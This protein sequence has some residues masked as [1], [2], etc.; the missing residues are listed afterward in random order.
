MRSRG[1]NLIHDSDFPALEDKLGFAKS[2]QNLAKFIER[3]DAPYSIHIDGDSGSGRTSYMRFIA[4][5]LEASTA[6]TP[7]WLDAPS[8]DEH[9]SILCAII[10]KL[11]RFKQSPEL[12]E[13]SLRFLSLYSLYTEQQ[14]LTPPLNHNNEDMERVRQSVETMTRPEPR[15]MNLFASVETIQDT[16][17]H[18]VQASLGTGG[19]RFFLAFVDDLDICKSETVDRFLAEAFLYT[20]IPG[21]RIVWIFTLNQDQHELRQG[22]AGCHRL[23]KLANLKV[24]VPA[25]QSPRSLINQYVTDL[26]LPEAKGLIN[27]FNDLFDKVPLNNPRAIKKIIARISYAKSFGAM[28]RP[29]QE[30]LLFYVLVLISELFPRFFAAIVKDKN[31]GLLVLSA[32]GNSHGQSKFNSTSFEPMLK[33]LKTKFEEELQSELFYIAVGYAGMLIG[34]VYGIRTGNVNEA[35]P[36]FAPVLNSVLQIF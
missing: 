6:L 29:S 23:N 25:P 34:K 20:S 27:Q 11:S 28:P 15:G 4:K 17:L 19:S 30:Q 18:F 31:A 14:G 33:P 26:G 24:R 7:L 36:R 5:H 8:I 22:E 21:S 1:S 12:D 9:G 13:L 3:L 35:V 32:A 10:N 16:F 2:A